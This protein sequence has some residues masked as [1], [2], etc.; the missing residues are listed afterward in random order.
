MAKGKRVPG[1]ERFW[2]KVH[3]RFDHDCWG[4]SGVRSPSGYSRFDEASGPTVQA[5]RYAYE[6][7]VGPIPDGYQLDHLCRNRWCVNPAHLEPVTQ[8]ENLRRGEGWS[9]VNAQ[10]N[11]CNYGHLFTPAN[12]Y[13]NYVGRRCRECQRMRAQEYRDRKKAAWRAESA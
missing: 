6:L 7:L 2:S 13:T 12:T 8:R 5:H 9:G 3:R 11:A 1:V 4:W 10:K